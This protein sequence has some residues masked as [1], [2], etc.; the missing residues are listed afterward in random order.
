MR[1]FI[2]DSLDIGM[3]IEHLFAWETGRAGGLSAIL[4]VQQ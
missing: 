2:C 1:I 4:S 3:K